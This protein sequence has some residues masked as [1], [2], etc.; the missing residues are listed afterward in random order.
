MKTKIKSIAASSLLIVFLFIGCTKTLDVIPVSTI[1]SSGFWKAPDDS[2]AYLVGIYDKLRDITNTTYYGDDR[3]DSF[4]PGNIGP[5][6]PAWAQSL[7]ATSEPGWGG[8]GNSWANFYNCIYHLNRLLKETEHIEFHVEADKD[9]IMAEGYSL[10]ALVYFQMARVWGDVPILLEPTEN[11]NVE[12]K[13]RAPVSQVFDQINADIN[14]AL[15]LFPEEGFVDKNRMSKPAT[16][17]LQADVKLWTAKVLGGGDADFNTALSAIAH[18]ESSGVQLLPNYKDVFSS[19]NKKNDEIIFSIYFNRDEQGGQYGRSL[20]SRGDNV[21]QADNYD[22]LNI[23][24]ANRAR[25]VYQPSQK[26]QD[27]YKQNPGDTREPVA[28]IHALFT[29]PVTGT[30]DTL[31]TTFNKFRGTWWADADDRYYDDDTPIYRFADI[32]LLKAEALAA[33]GR[34]NEAITELNKTRNRAGIG[35][36]TGATDKQSV[37]LEVLNERWR[38]LVVENKRW[39]DLVRFNAEGVINIYN[40]VPNLKGKDGYPLYFPVSQDVLDNNPNITQT[41]GY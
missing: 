1:T 23:T 24:K 14:Q 4:D 41:V 3:G 8:Q 31:L 36:Y 10:R 29:N 6:S 13:K 28:V 18:V 7:S 21:S 37:E 26:L 9:R 33:L 30:V 34:T 32:I 12:L 39:F 17:A 22:Q 35:D 40:V 15:S 16:Y 27:L 25:A 38:E 11:A 5:V 20:G 19:D 2:K